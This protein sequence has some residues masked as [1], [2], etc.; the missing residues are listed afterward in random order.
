MSVGYAMPPRRPATGPAAGRPLTLRA[1]LAADCSA[2]PAR[3]RHL[4]HVLALH[5]DNTTGRG[6][7]GQKRLARY[8]GVSDRHVRNLLAELEKEWQAGRSP[9]G[10]LREGR[11]LNSDRYTLVV[12]EDAP[13]SLPSKAATRPS[14]PRVVRNPSSGNNRNPSSAMTGTPVPLE[15]NPSSGQPPNEPE[16]QFLQ[17][18]EVTLQSDPHSLRE[19]SFIPPGGADAPAEKE[20]PAQAA[21]GGGGS[22]SLEASR[23]L[24]ARTL[25]ELRRRGA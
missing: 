8:L 22:P 11:W 25:A 23:A 13:L 1:M 5:A 6:L 2:L 3:L 24:A 12:R 16:P 15:R 17:S 18:T 20:K 14:G 9:V 4:I 21:G 19:Q 10:V 7:T